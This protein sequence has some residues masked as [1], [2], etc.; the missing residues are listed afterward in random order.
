MRVGSRSPFTNLI[1][2]WAILLAA[3]PAGALPGDPQTPLGLQ[4]ERPITAAA[5]QAAAN[6]DKAVFPG[7]APYG[8]L[9]DADF[10]GK[11]LLGTVLAGT[12][13]R[14]A[15]F[16]GVDLRQADL[17]GAVL[18][19]ATF[20]GAKLLL[21]QQG[22][23][24]F[25]KADLSGA[26]WYHA[27]GDEV[28]VAGWPGGSSGSPLAVN[29]PE[30]GSGNESRI[31]QKKASPA[32]DPAPAP[33]QE[34]PLGLLASGKPILT[35]SG[36]VS[37]RQLDQAVFLPKANLRDVDFS[38]KSLGGADLGAAD[39][40]G[41]RFTGVDL[42][43]TV[44]KGAALAGAD[45]T[46]ARV[47]AEDVPWLEAQGADLGRAVRTP[48]LPDPCALPPE[49]PG[50]ARKVAYDL[51][52]YRGYRAAKAFWRV[53]GTGNVTKGTRVGPIDLGVWRM[54]QRGRAW[55]KLMPWQRAAIEA[56]PQFISDGRSARKT[57]KVRPLP[58]AQAIPQLPGPALSAAPPRLPSLRLIPGVP[59][60][61]PTPLAITPDDR[62]LW[63]QAE[64]AGPSLERVVFLPGADLCGISFSGKDLHLL[65]HADL[66]MARCDG[67]DF[68]GL[69]LRTTVLDGIQCRGARFLGAIL[70]RK[71][72]EWAK[73][74][75][76][77]LRGA[78]TDDGLDG[79][80]SP[81][82]VEPAAGAPR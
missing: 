55:N 77:D 68:S 7:K 66:G 81:A 67:A 29:L 34:P 6:L 46:G 27:S 19:G 36:L 5:F 40:S 64:L 20:N 11:S 28:P 39:C 31:E 50:S 56:I 1:R 74:M 21:S 25:S 70:R 44:L 63:N 26:L 59:H 80:G 13:C 79:L 71:D 41:A 18:D 23:A 15:R 22:G 49:E 42:T 33:A 75:G 32:A 62:P 47:R 58:P 57:P 16:D 14:R 4:G 37:L 2:P 24:G 3:G 60:G 51:A 43:T 30:G 45:F 69:D 78:F 17:G 48:G 52:W 10:R 8:D 61:T 12:D 35:R 38:D 54:N 73:I 65:K 82:L 9:Q 53:R 72:Y 76:A